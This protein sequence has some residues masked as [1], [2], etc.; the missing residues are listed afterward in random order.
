MPTWV[1]LIPAKTW[2]VQRVLATCHLQLLCSKLLLGKLMKNES[3][4]SQ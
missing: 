2:E 4:I 3:I 1:M